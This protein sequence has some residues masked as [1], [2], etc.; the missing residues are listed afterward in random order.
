MDTRYS[1]TARAGVSPSVGRNDLFWQN[2]AFHIG[3][4]PHGVGAKKPAKRVTLYTVLI[5]PPRDCA[6]RL[7]GTQEPGD[8][9][10][11]PDGSG[12][13]LE[14]ACVATRTDHHGS[15]LRLHQ[16]FDPDE[17]LRVVRW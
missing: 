5:R 16:R 6:R 17:C 7:R 8:P 10:T 4:A 14:S 2:R 9:R 12:S 11:Y 13:L 1:T 15:D 3:V